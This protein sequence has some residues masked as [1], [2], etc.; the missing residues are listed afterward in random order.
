M[1]VGVIYSQAK[2]SV[3]IFILEIS[4]HNIGTALFTS[5]LITNNNIN[6]SRI[7]FFYFN[8]KRGDIRIY[9]KPKWV[10]RIRNFRNHQLGAFMG[11]FI[12]K[13]FT[14]VHIR[15]NFV[16]EWCSSQVTTKY[17]PFIVQISQ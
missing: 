2:S 16:S 17:L 8:H 5:Y 4:T 7:V 10:R 12:T 11:K 14:H 9:L 1:L 15:T 6:T 3:N 13:H